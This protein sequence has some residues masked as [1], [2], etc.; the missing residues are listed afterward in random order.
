MTTSTYAIHADGINNYSYA[1]FISIIVVSTSNLL[2][3]D[4]SGSLHSIL[5]LFCQQ[6]WECFCAFFCMVFKENELQAQI[7]K[8][9]VSFSTRAKAKEGEWDKFLLHLPL[10]DL[11][12][13]YYI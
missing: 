11:T 1:V 8:D 12:K 2:D 3:P 6:E 10:A 5:G 13:L 7:Y 9:A 4:A